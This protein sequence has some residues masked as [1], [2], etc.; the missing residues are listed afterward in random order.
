MGKNYAKIMRLIDLLNQ[1]LLTEVIRYCG[2]FH[3]SSGILKSASIFLSE[4]PRH[5]ALGPIPNF[6]KALHICSF[7]TLYSLAAILLLSLKPL[8]PSKT[9]F[10]AS[11]KLGFAGLSL[12]LSTTICQQTGYPFVFPSLSTTLRVMA[13][14]VAH[15]NSPMACKN[16]RTP[17]L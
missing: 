5:R 1:A 13:I 17:S 9:A 6:E 12:K 11:R 7:T 8:S 15:H 4:A 2:R 10:R 14:N 16:L 3:S